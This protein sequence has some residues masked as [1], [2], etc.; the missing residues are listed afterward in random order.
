MCT[1]YGSQIILEACY[2]NTPC[3]AECYNVNNPN[4]YIK[5]R[6]PTLQSSVSGGTK[7][8]RVHTGMHFCIRNCEFDI[9][10]TE[11]DIYPDRNNYFNETSVIYRMQAAG[12]IIMWLGD[13]KNWGS[14][15]CVKRYSSLLKS[16]IVQVSHHGWDG[17][18][19]ALYSVL[20][21]KT[22]LWPAAKSVVEKFASSS[23]SASYYAVDKYLI[24]KYGYDNII[25]AEPTQT[26]TL[27]YSNG[28]TIVTE[29]CG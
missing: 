10:Y 7:M 12:Q 17:S 6:F 9:L 1:T 15:T 27:P 19:L 16:D 20:D 13:N 5:S 18:T 26:I 4:Y 23:S 21:A 25:I 14:N 11:E 29:N 3:E 22:L 2:M 24:K 28:D 8:I